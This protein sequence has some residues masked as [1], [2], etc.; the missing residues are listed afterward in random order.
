MRFRAE[1]SEFADAVTWVYRTVGDRATLPALSGIRLEVTGDRLVLS[2]TNLEMESELGIAVQA[3]RAGLGLVLGKLL[4][5]VVRSLPPAGIVAEVVGDVLHLECGRAHFALRLMPAEDFPTLRAPGSE[6]PVAVMKAEEFARTVGQVVRAASSDDA[7][8]VLTGVNLEATA[9]GVTAAATDSYRLA[10]RTVPWEQG[11]DKTVLVPRRALEQA[12]HAADLLGSE[13]RL[14]LEATQVSFVFGDRRLTTRLIEG[15]FPDY[16]QLIPAGFQRRLEVDRAELIE[17]VKRVAVVGG[18]DTTSSPVTL[19]LS[20][21]SVRVTAGSGEVGQAE[22]SLPGRLEGEDLEIAFN[23]RY[24]TDGLEAAD[25]ERVVLEFRDAV[26]PA[27]V[28]PLPAAGPA[29]GGGQ[30]AEFLYLLM[31]VRV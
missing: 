26:K 27:V 14:V 9:D 17:V 3:E 18:A 23:P 13:V 8:P 7:R 24:L 15:R 30:R 1:R 21:D 5:D 28:R 20:A 29:E 19:Y 6:G 31:P 10:V 16:R 22:E 11:A 25:G 4:A 2:S 12:R